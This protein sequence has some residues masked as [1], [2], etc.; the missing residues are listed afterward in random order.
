VKNFR[1]LQISHT[2]VDL[3][4]IEK[5]SQVMLQNKDE[6]NG[7]LAVAQSILNTKEQND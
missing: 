4:V 1:F 5:M 6:Q 3:L 7:Q 2:V